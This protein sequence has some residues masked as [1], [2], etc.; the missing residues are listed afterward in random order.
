MIFNPRSL[1]RRL[2]AFDLPYPTVPNDF[3]G[4]KISLRIKTNDKFRK[5]WKMSHLDRL[6]QSV[7]SK[8]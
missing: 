8:K 1:G 3:D 7:L 5:S 2:G 4:N 6:Q